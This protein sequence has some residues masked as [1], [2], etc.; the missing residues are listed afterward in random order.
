M[1]LQNATKYVAGYTQGL[2]SDG[3]EHLVVAIKGTF[4]IPQSGEQLKIAEDQIPL[5]EAD[6]FIGEPGFSAPV[7]ETDYAAYKPKCDVILNG[8]A[9]APDGKP[10]IKVPVSMQIGPISKSFYVI[11]HRV[12]QK[13]ITGFRPTSTVPFTK[14]PISYDNAF[15]GIDETHEKP[16]KHKACSTNPVGVGFHSNLENELVEGK[17]LP[18]TE[19]PNDPVTKPKGNYQPM[20]YGPIGRAWQPRAPL[21]GTYDQNWI[22]N[23][24]PFLPPDFKDEYYQSAP[25]DQ[26]MPYPSGGEKIRLTN[27]TPERHTDITLPDLTM[28]ITFYFK[29]IKEKETNAVV[30]T[31]VIEPDESRIMITWRS[32]VPLRKNMLEVV[33]VVVGTMSKG[34][35]RALQ[36][37]KDYYPSPGEKAE[38]QMKET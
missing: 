37:G 17:P 3:R 19:E 32:S 38:S 31:I 8:S 36:V 10:A 25:A 24:F 2:R 28:P 13:N 12:W 26:Q 1:E 35:Y 18:N 27:L 16:A 5:V 7:Y 14:M 29:D 6:V 21:A 22:D 30:D 23:I 4:A 9:Y 33:Q 34:W 15:G 20:A 11:G